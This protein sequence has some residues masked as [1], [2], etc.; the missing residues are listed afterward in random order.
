M[1]FAP[2]LWDNME[3]LNAEDA[4]SY[5]GTYENS[6]YQQKWFC[7]DH[8]SVG[9]GGDIRGLSDNALLWIAEGARKQGLAI[10]TEFDKMLRPDCRASLKNVSKLEGLRLLDRATKKWR[11]G[12]TRL[13]ETSDAARERW[14]HASE[15]RPQSLAHVAAKL[16]PPGVLDPKGR[17]IRN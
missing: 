13:E 9:G 16:E 17:L 1:I 14:R 2:T 3:R 12:P 8:G 11:E 15:Y 10:R 4:S 5:D 7:G 6:P